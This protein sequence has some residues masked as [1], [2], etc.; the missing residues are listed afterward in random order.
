[1]ALILV[2]TSAVYALIDRDDRNHAPAKA[3]LKALKRQKLEPFLTNFLVAETHALLLSRLGIDVA[4]QW[5]LAN[6]WRIESVIP[7]DEQKA[8]DI[9]RTYVDKDFSYTDASSFAVMERLGLETAFTFDRH[10]KQYG[11]DLH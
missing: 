1:M 7:S 11:F 3:K 9:I 8:R 10:F 6:V 5:L 2:D 4:R